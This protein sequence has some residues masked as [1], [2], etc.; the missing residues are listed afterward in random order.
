M[1]KMLNT[2]MCVLLKSYPIFLVSTSISREVLFHYYVDPTFIQEAQG[3]HRLIETQ[4][5]SIVSFI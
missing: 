1:L 3:Q 4:L 5:Q 2:Y